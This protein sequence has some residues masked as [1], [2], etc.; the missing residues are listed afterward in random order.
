MSW[1]RTMPAMATLIAPALLAMP[2]AHAQETT[3]RIRISHAGRAM[4]ATLEDSATTRDLLSLLP[5][6][7][8]LEDH[9]ATEK[10]GD[11]PR[12]LTPEGA[13]AGHEP[14]AG[15]IAYYAPWGNL[16]L[17]HK[18]F[19]Y[20]PGLI[21]LG[22]IDLDGELLKQSGNIQVTIEPALSPAAN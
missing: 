11:L 19:G 1:S 13:P 21:R 15:D 16:A 10:I 12:K 18:P 20:S 2:G 6:T 7:L 8:A 9:A 22:R 3:M 5:L 14:S 4:T 17:F